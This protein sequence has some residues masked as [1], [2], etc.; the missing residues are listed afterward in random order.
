M[1]QDTTYLL[2]KNVLFSDIFIFLMVIKSG[3]T[4]R[5]ATFRQN[6]GPNYRSKI[7][8][9]LVLMIFYFYYGKVD[10]WSKATRDK[11]LQTVL[12][13]LIYINHMMISLTWPLHR[14]PSRKN[15]IIKL[16]EK[17]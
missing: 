5:L 9:Y 4:F 6:Y 10:E 15:V 17:H 14:K 8:Q 3:K 12:C 16:Q 1:A 11:W 2:R 13:I 7:K